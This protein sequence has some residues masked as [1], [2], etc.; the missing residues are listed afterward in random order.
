LK[1]PLQRSAL[2]VTCDDVLRDSGKKTDAAPEPIPSLLLLAQK[3]RE[4]YESSAS[5]EAKVTPPNRG[6]EVSSGPLFSRD[7]LENI[8]HHIHQPSQTTTLHPEFPPGGPRWPATP[9]L[10]LKYDG[11]SFL[12]KDESQNP[13]G[14]HKD[15]WAW[16]KIVQYKKIIQDALQ[17]PDDAIR[18][19]AYSMI[20]SGSAALAL[21]CMLRIYQLPDLHVAVDPSRVKPRVINKLRAHGAHVTE[22]GLKDELL[23]ADQVCAETDNPDGRD[24]TPRQAREPF[25]EH[26]YDW[27]VY[28]I[29]EKKPKHIFVPFGSGG[30]FANIMYIIDAEKNGERRDDRLREGSAS[31]ENVNLYGATSNDDKTNM[32]MLFAYHRPMLSGIEQDLGRFVADGTLGNH[33]K[34][35]CV[36]NNDAIKAVLWAQGAG[37]RTDFSGAAGLALFMTK[38]NDIPPD[39][40]VIV[41]NTGTIALPSP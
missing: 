3:F 33:S 14:T 40:T 5:E 16:E 29:L 31:I 38:S 28:E 1:G 12:I 39:E 6:K 10:D 41:V 30:L 37:V 9:C 25:L 24:V 35:I 34:I 20:S 15:R 11:H 4:H 32:E 27:L 36:G 2:L 19:P 26:H 22:L 13:S 8:I 18:L 23:S 17:A 21:Q 7:Q